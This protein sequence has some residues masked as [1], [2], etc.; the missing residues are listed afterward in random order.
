MIYGYARVSTAA[1]AREGNSLESQEQALRTHGAT[2]IY[3]D[4]TTGIRI[5]RP[6]LTAL[7]SALNPGDTL[8]ITKLDRVAR[9]LTEG[10]TLIN[11][12][13]DRGITLHIL[14]LGK[15]D[16]TPASRLIRN[17]FL[18]FAEFE[19]EMIIERCEEGKAIARTKPGYREGRPKKFT[20]DQ[21]SHA[22]TLLTTHSYS[23]TARMTGISKPTLQRVKISIE[24]TYPI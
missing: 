18:S 16:T 1:Q 17:I 2:E 24:E 7:I 12:L 21:L 10:I 4:T 23:Q 11:A 3:A 14:N 9:S 19:R 22:M 6:N 8:I 5:D 13:I 15:L 20:N